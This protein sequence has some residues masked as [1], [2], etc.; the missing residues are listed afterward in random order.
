VDLR[1]ALVT[2]DALCRARHNASYA[3]VGVM[4]MGWGCGW[5]RWW[6]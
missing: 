4:P 5:S 1:G 6:S 3:D 2:A